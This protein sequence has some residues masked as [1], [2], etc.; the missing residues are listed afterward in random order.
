[1]KTIADL[2]A[3][4]PQQGTLRW[5]GVRPERRAAMQSIETAQLLA[6]Q[7]IAGDRASRRKG[8]RR[9]ISLLQYEHLDAIAAYA[10]LP[11]VTPEQLRRN[12]IVSGINLLALRE[13]RFYIGE[14]LLEGTGPCHPCS[15]M[16][17]T[18]GAGGFNAVR[19]HGGIIARVLTPGLIH[20]GDDV[21]LAK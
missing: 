17:E 6:D 5:I 7:G 21:R 12:L 20:L 4:L 9:Q 18:L 13:Q 15:R 3:T 2:K 14:V 19:G 10:G 11:Q 16:E 1:M 8:H